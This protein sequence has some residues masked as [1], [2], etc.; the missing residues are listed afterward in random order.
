MYFRGNYDTETGICQQLSSLKTHLV[1]GKDK[2][3]PGGQV[4][5]NESLSLQVLH[6]GRYLHAEVTQPHDREGGSEGWFLEALQQ[7]TQGGQLCH[8]HRTQGVRH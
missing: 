5:V 1:F 7:G 2:Y 6:A 4:S 3:V 8:L